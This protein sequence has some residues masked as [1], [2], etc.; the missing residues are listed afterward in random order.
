MEEGR[1]GRG[2][3][4]NVQL[5][6]TATLSM[7]NIQWPIKCVL[8]TECNMWCVCVHTASCLDLAV[9]HSIIKYPICYKFIVL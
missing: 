1:V 2:G 5:P 4:G 7:G 9:G 3:R 6:Y 8:H